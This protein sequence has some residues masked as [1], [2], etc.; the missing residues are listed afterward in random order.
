MSKEEIHNPGSVANSSNVEKAKEAGQRVGC[1]NQ[2]LDEG[3]PT[4]EYATSEKAVGTGDNN[5]YIIV[6][7]D[8]PTNL[9]SGYG[10]ACAT[11]AGRIDLIAGLASSECP[12]PRTEL[13]N[14][15]FSND[16]ARV[17][18][19][20]KANIDTYMGLATTPEYVSEGKSAVGIKA[21]CIRIHSR[22]DIK[23]VSG[24]MKTTGG[25]EKLST[26]GLN[27]I[28]GKIYLIAG[29]N[30]GENSFS[31]V[32]LLSMGNNNTRLKMNRS[33]DPKL[34]PIPKGDRLV[35]LLTEIIDI[36]SEITQEINDILQ[37]MIQ[38]QISLGAHIHAPAVPPVTGP[39]PTHAPV[40]S[41]NAG[42]VA[43]KLLNIQFL[44]KKLTMLKTN[45]LRESQSNR[46]INSNYV[47]VT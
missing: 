21:D 19:S 1:H 22:Q 3:F 26:G 11:Q 14:P 37:I 43:S 45:Y 5:S 39:S 9:S 29:N 10:G 41:K 30:T 20:Q 23:I 33:S 36:S 15:S 38:D 35:G 8:R 12:L 16:A 13:R 40:A 6:G 2:P 7:R 34:Q 24:R 42:D 27:E 31:T 47:F 44:Q 4:F 25:N 28:P 32:N 46:Y 17:Y 18:I